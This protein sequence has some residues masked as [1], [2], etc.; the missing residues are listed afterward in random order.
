[1][2]CSKRTTTRANVFLWQLCNSAGISVSNE[3]SGYEAGKKDLV[4][5]IVLHSFDQGRESSLM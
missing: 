5:A 3:P 1:M 4:G 2:T